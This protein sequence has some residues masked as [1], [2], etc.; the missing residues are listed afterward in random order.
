MPLAQA[1]CGVV[2]GHALTLDDQLREPAQEMV[3]LCL[4][5]FVDALGMVP[6]GVY[7][8]PSRDRVGPD[9]GVDGLQICTDIFWCTALLTIQLKVVLFGA[10]VEDR[11]GVCSSKTFEKLLVCRRQ[12]IIDFITRRPKRVTAG[13]WQFSQSKDGVVAWNGLESDVTVPALLAALLLVSGKAFGIQI[14]GLLRADHRDLIIFA[15][16]GAT[17]VGDGMNMKLGSS[18]FA[19]ELAQALCQFLLEIIVEVILFAE[20]D[21]ATLGY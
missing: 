7:T 10:L 9:H 21:D 17:T 2:K 16:K 5:D 14:L 1:R 15:A 20:E 11:L 18:G 13:L 4:G 19:G 6:N 12:A 3:T 8:F